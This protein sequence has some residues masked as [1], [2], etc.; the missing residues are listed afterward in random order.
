MDIGFEGDLSLS[1]DGDGFL[2]RSPP[3]Q[4]GADEMDICQ[5]FGCGGLDKGLVILERGWLDLQRS[6][7]ARGKIIAG[8]SFNVNLLDHLLLG[9]LFPE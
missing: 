1:K 2:E 8:P 5:T 4:P 9:L 3:V 6:I 7:T